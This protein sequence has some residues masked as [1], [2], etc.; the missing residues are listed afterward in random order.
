MGTVPPA[1]RRTLGG[2]PERSVSE[3]KPKKE[4]SNVD[5]LINSRKA[6]GARLANHL[7][8]VYR[9]VDSENLQSKAPDAS[10]T[11]IFGGARLCECFSAEPVLHAKQTRI[12]EQTFGGAR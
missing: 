7:L 8:H 5:S 3:T 1:L 4:R 11:P 2:Q 10:T 9:H 12:A 6:R